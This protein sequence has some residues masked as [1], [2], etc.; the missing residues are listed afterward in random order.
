MVR[1]LD[2]ETHGNLK[3]IVFNESFSQIYASVFSVKIPLKHFLFSMSVEIA[4]CVPDV[5]LSY[6]RKKEGKK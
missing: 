2:I 5:I 1:I 3:Y 4:S 6:K